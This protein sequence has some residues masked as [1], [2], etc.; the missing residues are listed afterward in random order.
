MIHAK[1][2]RATEAMEVHRRQ[3]ST[4]AGCAK[5]RVAFSDALASVRRTPRTMAASGTSRRQR[6]LVEVPRLMLSRLT[7]LACRAARPKVR[8]QLVVSSIVMRVPVNWTTSLRRSW[9]SASKNCWSSWPLSDWPSSL[10]CAGPFSVVRSNA[11]VS[12]W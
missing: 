12:A 3:V 9:P 6:D 1:R 10:R 11:C 2:G 5:G 7:A 4:A 8:D